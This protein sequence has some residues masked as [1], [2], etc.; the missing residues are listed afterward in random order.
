MTNVQCAMCNVQCP[1]RFGLL[2]AHCSLLIAHCSMLPALPAAEP[3][4][5]ERLSV[6]RDLELWFD[7]S[8]QNAGRGGLQLAPLAAGNNVDY[9]LD[10]SGRGRHLAQ[11]VLERRPRF[12]QE[13][14][15]AFLSFD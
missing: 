15:G 7:L 6:T 1:G 4:A 9:L 11:P 14:A 12:R 10:G 3:W 5:D 13:F 2:I 8:R